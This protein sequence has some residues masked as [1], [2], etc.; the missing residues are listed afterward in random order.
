MPLY[1]VL[2]ECTVAS[3]ASP[4]GGEFLLRLVKQLLVELCGPREG[5]VSFREV[6]YGNRPD[7]MRP[8]D[9][10]RS[11]PTPP[12]L[13]NTCMQPRCWKGAKH[14]GPSG[15]LAGSSDVG[16]TRK[17]G[18]L[19]CYY[20]RARKRSA[21]TLEKERL[22]RSSRSVGGVRKQ[23]G[24]WVGLWREDGVKKSRVLGLCKGM[25]KGEARTAV[26][27]IVA[28]LR[29]NGSQAWLGPFVEQTYFPFY[30]RKW[31]ASTRQENVWRV[32]HHILS[33]FA[34]RALASIHRDEL[35]DFID[36]K[37]RQFSFSVVDHLRWDLNQIFTMAIAEGLLER[38]PAQ[39]LFTPKEAAKPIRRAMN[40]AD[41][42]LCLS[43]LDQ[44]ERL[45]LKLA[46]LAGMRPGEIFGLTWPRMNASSAEI[47]Q[48]VYRG[49]IDTPKTK[50]S[51]RKVALSEGLVID[52]EAWR[53]ACPGATWVFPSEAGT[54][55]SKD[56]C[57]R[58]N[59]QPKLEA[60]GL[61]WVNFQ[62]IRRTHATLM[63]ELGADPKLSADQMGHSLDVN[64]NVYTQTSVDS[65]L[66]IVNKLERFVM[67]H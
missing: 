20:G 43:V 50:Q 41:V 23:Q 26:S 30:T 28:G 66:V 13:E 7:N 24:R 34:D 61:G 14:P 37:A 12:L 40:I 10:G 57:W 15:D 5:E 25:T 21:E 3:A 60:A 6:I 1:R 58:R 17:S 2:H 18:C 38:N 33:R 63:K 47:L 19:D 9:D 29:K 22:M 45:I 44:R 11:G 35:Q 52:I 65:R 8:P 32:T 4:V 36:A 16:A 27:K 46:I 55:M 39:L 49:L 54:P 48:R 31:K 42:Q 64:Q 59:I 62:V 56:N 53:S 67:L 51:L